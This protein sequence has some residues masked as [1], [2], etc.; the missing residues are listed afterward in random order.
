MFNVQQLM[1]SSVIPACWLYECFCCNYFIS[2]LYV[3]CFSFKG[4]CMTLEGGKVTMESIVFWLLSSLPPRKMIRH[5]LP[6]YLADQHLPRV[7][8]T[9]AMVL[10]PV[11]A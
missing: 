11:I 4:L 7:A 2:G 5:R 10:F 3:V 9:Y 1:D 6:F 8:L